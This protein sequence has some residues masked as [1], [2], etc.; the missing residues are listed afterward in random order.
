VEKTK[1]K[2]QRKK[3]NSQV[4]K[5]RKPKYTWTRKTAE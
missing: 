4:L 2:K 1:T 3:E 5:R